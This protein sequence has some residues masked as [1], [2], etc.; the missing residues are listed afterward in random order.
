M[1]ARAD[2]I[3]AAQ[4]AS[5]LAALSQAATSVKQTNSS[6]SLLKSP[7][8]VDS[9][10]PE[11]S[12]RQA[13]PAYAWQAS[14]PTGPPDLLP[15]DS[16]YQKLQEWNA[17]YR[18]SHVPHHCH[19]AEVLGSWVRCMRRRQR[20]GTLERWKTEALDALNFTWRLS[21]GDAQWHANLH[22]LRQLTALHGGGLSEHAVARMRAPVLEQAPRAVGQGAETAA[23]AAKQ[24]AIMWESLG[25]AAQLRGELSSWHH[26]QGVLLAAGKLPAMKQESLAAVGITLEVPEQVSFRRGQLHGQSGS[27]VGLKALQGLKGAVITTPCG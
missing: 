25:E 18:T 10:S 2:K 12:S 14:D 24:R 3:P 26:E 5:L 27:M 8:L 22:H 17:K 6:I 23:D 13:M 1:I 15:F 21:K 4:K 20:R 19:D 9:P 11:G 7:G 16:M